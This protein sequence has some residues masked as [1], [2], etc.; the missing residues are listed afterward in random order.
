MLDFIMKLISFNTTKNEK[1]AMKFIEK[2]VRNLHGN[3]LMYE[4]QEI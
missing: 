1:D 4:K 2:Y 3:T